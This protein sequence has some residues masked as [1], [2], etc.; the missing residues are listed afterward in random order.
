VRVV[1]KVL[2][3]YLAKVGTNPNPATPQGSYIE[4]LRHGPENMKTCFSSISYIVLFISFLLEA[5]G[6][7]TQPK[8]RASAQFWQL[9]EVP[10]LKRKAEAGDREAQLALGQ[11]LST[12][13]RPADALV[14]YRKAAA[15]GSAVGAWLAGE[16][17]MFG[18]TAN[19]DDQ[20]VVAK[21]EEGLALTY[22]AA[23]NRNA[24]AWHNMSLAL[25]RGLTGRTN[26]VEA[27]AWLRLYAEMNPVSRKREL[28]SLALV[29]SIEDLDRANDI[30][31]NARKGRWPSYQFNREYKTDSRLK[32]SGVSVG[33]RV[34]MAIINRRTLAV[35]ESASI[36]IKGETL[37]I[38]CLEIN[39][40]SV[41]VTIDRAEE[42]VQLTIN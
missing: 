41:I 23:T 20:R 12:R 31:Q 42:P 7:A 28:D 6:A 8:P 24:E 38:T 25:Q 34:P 4:R 3:F 2:K 35:G 40:N 10:A 9:G 11:A 16:L 13:S 5:S 17:L 33:G 15:Q 26:N 39:Q 21:P 32:L 1:P 22:F 29:L 27:Y 19:E 30:A 36:V 14:W 37:N 18:K